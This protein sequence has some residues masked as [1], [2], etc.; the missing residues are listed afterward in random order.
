MSLDPEKF[1]VFNEGLL[2]CAI[3]LLLKDLKMD[4]E[5]GGTSDDLDKEFDLDLDFPARKPLTTPDEVLEYW[6]SCFEKETLTHLHFREWWRQK[7]P[8]IFSPIPSMNYQKPLDHIEEEDV[9]KY[10]FNLLERFLCNGDPKEVLEK[11]SSLND[12]PANCGKV[13]KIGEPTYSC[14]DCGLDPTCVLCVE[15]FKNSEHGT[16]RYKMSTSVG[17]GYCDCG[18]AEAWKEHP[19]CAVHVLGTQTDNSDPL[20][21]VPVDIQQRAR[22]VFTGV[23]KYA[24][25]L[26][27]LDTFMKLPGDLQYKER[28]SVDPLMDDL[29]EVEDL[30]A[31]VL[32]ND[33]VHTF[34]EVI[35]TL[36]RAVENCDRNLAISF[37]S[38]IDREGRCLVKCGPYQQCNEVK[39]VVERRERRGIKAL[40]VMVI[41]SHV[42]AHQVFA[43]RLISWL[44]GIL[45]YSEGFRALFSKILVEQEVGGNGKKQPSILEGM[46]RRDTVLWKAARSAIHHLLI[47]GMLLEHASK[48]EFAT[49]FTNIY[50]AIVK[51][52][53]NDDHEHSF[54]VTSLSVQLFTV[55]TLAHYLVAHQ[56][57][58]AVLLRTFQ[59]ECERKKNA[60]G[61]LEFERNL[62]LP[63][64]R[65]ANF[66]LVDLKYLLSV[67]PTEFDDNTRRGFLH[68]FSMMLD[69]LS[70]MQGMDCHTR[71][72]N[73]HIEF[74]A[75][76]ENGFNLHIKLA[77]VIALLLNW[78]Y[79]DKVI[80]LK[81]YRM[82]LK[83]LKEETKSEDFKTQKLELEGKSAECVVFNV[84]TSPVSLHLPLCRLLAGMSLHLDKFGLK[85]AG[86]DFKL[87]EEEMPSL[88][89]VLE[90]PLRTSV[91]VSQVH[92][93]MWRR[94]GYS[95]Q[96]Q[97]FFYHNARCRG[98]MYDRDIQAMQFCAA[99]M[100]HDSFLL[101]VLDKFGLLHWADTDFQVA[102]EESI[103][104]LTSLV[105]EFFGF[106]V[107]IIGERFTPGVGDITNEDM[108][109]KEIIQL[110]CVEP[111]S[112]SALNKALPEDVNHETGL[113]KVIDQV[114]TFK[115]PVGPSSKG[116][117]ELKEEFYKDYDV[118]FYHFTREDQSKSEEAQ[119]ARL[120]AANKPQVCPPPSLPP[121]G[122][123]FYGL[124]FLLQSDQMLH[125]MKLVLQRADDLKS[126]CFSESQVQKVLYLIG[127]ALVEEERLRKD[128]A[129]TSF[130]FTKR[131]LEVNMLETMEVL[132]GSHRIESHRELL[133]WT[134][135]KFRSVSG[136]EEKMEVVED[137]EEEDDEAKKKRA[138]AAAERRK[139]IMAQM[140]SQQK[141]FMTE[142]SQ[143]FEDT[144]SGLRERHAST[145]DWED[146]TSIDST[147]PVCL[148]PNRSMPVP[149][150]TSF[151]CILCQEEEELTADN[152][153]LVMASYCQKS[154]VLSR[155]RASTPPPPSPSTFPF[156]PS[157][158]S[159]APHTSSC[160]HVMHATCWQKYFDDVSES[161]RR[162]YRTRHPTSFDIEKSEF[163]CPLCRSLSNSVIPLIPQYHLLQ[164]PGI[165]QQSESMETSEMPVPTSLPAMEVSEEANESMEIVATDMV[166]DS[167]EE[168]TETAPNL[169]REE[170][171]EGPTA[172]VVT[173]AASESLDS[174]GHESEA[175][176]AGGHLDTAVT[177]TV[178]VV[179]SSE[180]PPSLPVDISPSSP[181]SS[182]SSSSTELASA[183][184][185]SSD[186]TFMSASES[187]KVVQDTFCSPIQQARQ[188]TNIPRTSVVIDFSQ[189]LEALFIALKYKRGL[190]P[191]QVSPPP[192]GGEGQPADS[193]LVITSNL[194]RYYTCPLDQVVE[195]LDQRHQDGASFSRLFMVDDGCEL[196]FPSSVYEIM[197]SFSQTTYRVGLEGTPHLQDERIPLM[198]WQSC[199]FTVH[200]IVVSAREAEKAL[201]G[202]LSSRQNDC[203][204][205]FIRFCGVVGS[206]FGEPKVIR[207]HSL[208]LLSTVLE[209]DTANPSILEVDMFGVLV[210]LTYS[211]PSLFNGEGPAPLP[212]C[213]IQDNHI[214]RLMFLAHVTQ[215]LFSMAHSL[216]TCT[217]PDF[218]H[219]PP[220]KDCRPLLDLIEVVTSVKTTPSTEE[221]TVPTIDP[222]AVWQE[223]ME[224]SIGF[225]R[226]C[227]LFYHYLSGV[228]APPELT[229]LLP[230]DQE[231]VHLTKYLAIP[232]SPKHLLDS[233]F[234][235]LLAKKWAN[236]PNV[237]IELST[238]APSLKFVT[239][240]PKLIDLPEDY[241]E[242]INNISNF[243]C[244]RSVGEE[245]R[246]PSMCLVC[247]TV[248]C[249]QSY[250]CQT[251]L[252]G[253][254]VGACTAHSHKCGAG[255]GLFLR[256]R[257][258]KLVMFSGRTKG[259]YMP[260]PYLDQYGETDQGLKRGNPLTLCS[261][262]YARLHRLW[263][264]H[265]IAEEVTHNLESSPGFVT[266]E[267]LHL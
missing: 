55:P 145:C 66:V 262:R 172:S 201:F 214:L 26:L 238:D 215:L 67:P 204:S 186:S 124:T 44:D 4:A 202:S 194:T 255:S 157:S 225:L 32:Y 110:L 116:V 121:L 102:E 69:I 46:L 137:T 82:L 147:F 111:M 152:S 5:G 58:L 243:S 91:M 75:D 267:W 50:G 60:K 128:D 40:K 254:T 217:K 213:N 245:S 97:I 92:A 80:F 86:D 265:G 203:L 233:P 185:M 87:M 79:S 260:P 113:E 85:Y 126:R 252:D 101:Q 39:R 120:K 105:E 27:T 28:D 209:V 179:S 257:E 142:N 160:G 104:H 249:S 182:H 77:P 61:K 216:P 229:S 9:Q 251:E 21:K 31:T 153:T 8:K 112:H 52:F 133:A 176:V 180:L 73:Q 45:A 134:I 108:V 197:N 235:L 84:A 78:C 135:R 106:L 200:S 159:S 205:T 219:C 20:A 156:L 94:N 74:E 63:A 149:T 18:D 130:I 168:I 22:H 188:T 141:N 237:H 118:F 244:P 206:N 207:S 103:R 29:L 23:L 227:A 193:D 129:N 171:P 190:S 256:V 3:K 119:R 144:P 231:F 65:R 125:L 224:Q 10:F 181:T 162:R 178:T 199:A 2:F 59:S 122:K 99:N 248:V 155:N 223:V 13:F 132:S 100:N 11:L 68:G 17:G 226:C 93:G 127:M 56:D 212:S 247:G 30:Y 131:A 187:P 38:L 246:I 150:E 98:E 259:C 16:H 37:V 250:C 173:E 54:S 70:W 158:L 123:N 161:E 88:N 258:C 35:T 236:H 220:A 42:V 211:L 53:I 64:F 163:L 90:M 43:M 49:V 234:S 261:E 175:P 95:L 228:A 169:V 12:P 239:T 136:V 166:T 139:R 107:T 72:V 154:T 109:R 89:L 184:S 170:T 76:W 117:Y 232:N 48:K 148:G 71:Q 7:V 240:I 208:K 266:T 143:L 195:E 198:V 189:W 14:R 165:S 33:E 115:K 177:S 222:M 140:A 192:N 15:C 230:P 6:N 151:T 24:Y 34:E 57:V 81:A 174:F 183:H 62:G 210:S 164:Q 218:R 138:K 196:A 264:N 191:E 1:Q 146:E 41:H 221:S 83:K 51:D 96:H 19:Y 114:A 263:L 25:E 242:L 241:S 36:T 253:V 47:S 167:V